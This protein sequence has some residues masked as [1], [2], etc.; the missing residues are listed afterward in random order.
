MS[1]PRVILS[2]IALLFSGTV[3]SWCLLA[4]P[5]TAEPGKQEAQAE[6]V[7]RPA[8]SGMAWIPGGKF[9][10]GSRDGQEDEKP[11]HETELSGYWIDTTEVTNAEFQRF[12]GA[13]GYVTLA[14]KTPTREDFAGVIDPSLITDEDLVAGSICFNPNFDRELVRRIR[15]P[16]N[17][18]WAHAVWRIQEGANWRHPHGPESGI[19]DKRDHP[20]VHVAWSDAVAY[21]Q[22]VGKR[23]P[24]EAEFEFAAR[25]GRHQQEYPWGNE[26]QDGDRWR[27]NL[28]QGEFPEE[29]DVQDGHR[30]T[31]A[32]KSFPPNGYGLYDIVGNVWEWCAD[33]YQPAYYSDSLRRNPRGPRD[34]LDPNEPKIPKRVQRGGSFMCNDNYCRG[35]RCAT[36]MKGDVNSSSFHCG[37]RGALSS[38]DYAAFAKAPAQQTATTR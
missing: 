30:F 31:S 16:S 4:P 2:L 28:W 35:Y 33:W 20:V 13:T 36:R 37:F 1:T 12:V 32:V 38:S 6:K 18:D 8:P 10:M 34:S 22:W 3:L 23:L 9:L 21:C 24:T 5:L 19:D 27:A 14:E 7:P 11:V 29:H 25:G 15:H 17:P 26:L